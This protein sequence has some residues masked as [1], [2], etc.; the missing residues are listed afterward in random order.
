MRNMT[1]FKIFSKIFYETIEVPVIVVKNVDTELN[2][3]EIKIGPLNK[4]D[5]IKIPY[6]LLDILFKEK[7]VDIDVMN[8]PALSEIRK[9]AWIESRSN[10]LQKLDKNFY[11]NASMLI[12]KLENELIE[13]YDANLLR[14]IEEIKSLLYDLVKCRLN[15]ILS[16]VISSH[17]P[18][19][20]LV[21]KM[22]EEEKILYTQLCN[23]IGDW[24]STMKKIIEGE[25]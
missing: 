7:I 8:I 12:K 22:T 5:R 21:E 3:G 20:E 25:I 4:G 15:K 10:E 6:R 13:N 9:I 18:S 23:H 2:I 17:I 24:F 19:R 16:L 11:I 14:E 1:A